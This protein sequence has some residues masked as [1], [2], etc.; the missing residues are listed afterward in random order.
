MAQIPWV[1][2]R[3]EASTVIGS[4][5]AIEQQRRPRRHEPSFARRD[6]T[7]HISPRPISTHTRPRGMPATE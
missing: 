3:L 4:R 5:P 7:E 2:E 6:K 1:G